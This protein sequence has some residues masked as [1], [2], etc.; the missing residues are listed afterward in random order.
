MYRV[1]GVSGGE[2]EEQGGDGAV[3]SGAGFEQARTEEGGGKPGPAGL[4]SG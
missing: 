3:G 2:P 4:S 1:K